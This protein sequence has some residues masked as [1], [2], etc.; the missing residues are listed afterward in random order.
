M[1]EAASSPENDRCQLLD[2]EVDLV[3]QTVKREG[4]AIELPDLSFRLLAALIRCAP[5]MIGKDALVREVWGEVV[6]SD[7]TLSQR[8]R[9]LRQ[10]LDEDGQDPRYMT[11]VRGRGYRLICPVE[12][13]ATAEK[14]GSPHKHWPVVL[15]A[16]LA[17]VVAALWPIVAGKEEAASVPRIH[18][19]AV[20][21]FADLSPNQDHGYFADGMQE[22]LLTQ[23]AK[24]KNL[25][26]ASRTTV[27]QYRSTAMSLPDIARELG[28]GAV[29]ESSIRIADNRVRITVQLIDAHTDRHLWAEVYD[30]EL[31]VQNIFS[32]QQEVAEQI[33]Q[34]LAL[35]YHSS[36]TAQSVLL[37]TTSIDAYNAYLI[38][39]H[40]MFQQ[41]PEDLALA[42]EY[43]EQAVAIDPEF[44]EAWASLGWAY[45]FLGTLYGGQSPRE[46]YPKAKQAATR[47]LSID[48]ELAGARA[49]YAD[50]LVWY[51]WDFVAAEREY[52][53]AL[54]LNPDGTLGYA[55][56]LSTQLRHE[57]AI[58]LIE[59][60]IAAYPDDPWVHINAGWIFLRAH[61]YER[62]IEKA[63][64][65]A[66][67]SDARPML[68]FAYLGLGDI[69]QAVEVFET[70]LRLQG[71]RQRQLSNLAVAY[72]K[73]GRVSEAQALLDELIA[74]A[75][76]Q[77]VSADFIADVYFAAGDTDKGFAALE[78]A[79]EA[80]SRGVI[81]LQADDALDGLREDPRY[82]ALIEA[83]GF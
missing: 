56:F 32:I 59:R 47:A 19:I 49:L 78:Q 65:V 61:Q 71:R 45:S 62:A 50:I 51:D 54:A 60:A 28:V 42:I 52:L 16:I 7:E 30:R 3:R 64:L 55:L 38:G 79:V 31:S 22:E 34:A 75:A 26:V 14:A 72:F 53:K 41:T 2:L 11:S 43:L 80:R 76:A 4:D 12:P 46:V 37:P 82:L 17:L 23:L 57:E 83:V 36:E 13:L 29:I 48:H 9:L 63:T 10:A 44:A 5:E 33:G 67:H 20:L 25:Q 69:E 24:L 40:Q 39:R 73:A 35:E 58:A 81:F 8:V 68:G 70:D 74:A 21:P 18:S 66:P 27:E 6:V 15:A 77:Y 1:G